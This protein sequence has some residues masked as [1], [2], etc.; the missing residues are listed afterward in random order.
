MSILLGLFFILVLIA[1]SIFI[2]LSEIAFAAA[3]EL[4][5]RTLAEAGNKR[6]LRFINLRARSGNVIT[7]LQISTNAVA[8]LAG[9]VGSGALGPIL[10]SS[11]A[12][13]LPLDLAT[14]TADI[15]AFIIITSVFVMFGD[16]VP[17]RVAMMIP[18]RTALMV[19]GFVEMQIRI[20]RPIVLLFSAI[21]DWIISLLRIEPDRSDEITTEDFRMIL[22]GGE[23][24][25]ALMKREH[26]L[27]N[28]VLALEMRSVT[29][30]MTVRDDIVFLD[31]N[32]TRETQREKVRYFPFSRYPLCDGGLDNVI[33]SVRAEDVLADAFDTATELEL[34]KI[35]RDMASVPD[36]LNVWEVLA[37]FQAQD[38]GVALVVSEYANVVGIVTFKDLMAPLVLGLANPFEERQIMQR[39][40]QSWLVDG[41]TPIVDVMSALGL[42]QIGFE[43]S[44]ETI[45]GFVVH[46]LRRAA[47][48]GDRVDAEGY[49]FEVVDADKM[50]LNQL[51]V[52]KIP[53]VKPAGP[54]K[55]AASS[56][57]KL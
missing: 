34:Q 11:L 56:E 23:A 25:G 29:S 41:V 45:G 53:P 4:R 26:Q 21:S 48:K 17:R 13:F 32:D 6:A 27:I 36:S 54:G 28:N 31:I 22:A 18:E 37:E 50:R 3:R 44:F 52:T 51:L 5:I 47:R 1:M 14:L 19:V 49:R 7:A 57:T 43:G 39:D 30:V 9:I 12:T 15:I 38:T 16:L 20:L 55:P 42:H 40:D 8:I 46:R 2:A 33:G 24:S 10:A 35:R